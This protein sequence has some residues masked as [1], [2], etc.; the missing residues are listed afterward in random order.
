M[1]KISSVVDVNHIVAVA[2]ARCDDHGVTVKFSK[3]ASTAS[4]NGKEIIIPA[5]KNPVTQDA[6]D[7]L[8][9]YL[10]HE[11]GHHIRG[12]V[13]KILKAAKPGPELGALYNIV[14][15]E[16]M[17]RDM[18]SRWRGDHIALS[19][20]NEIIMEEVVD[21]WLPV[22]QA[23]PPKIP[24]DENDNNPI[25]AMVLQQMARLK[26]DTAH[27]VD[28]TH[29]ISNLPT[30]VRTLLD[31]LVN[32][33][34]HDKMAASVTEYD[35]WNTACELAKR[36]YPD[37][38]EEITTQQI[39]GNS[40]EEREG[41][42]SGTGEGEDSGEE[43][44]GEALGQNN[45][46]EGY[47]ISWKDAVLS[48]HDQP[49]EREGGI[50]GVGITW[51]DY[52]GGSVAMAPVKEINV[53]KLATK[54]EERSD[55]WGGVGAPSSFMCADQE[56]RA[57][58][59]QV[60]RY[61]QS[62]AKAQVSRHKRHGMLDKSALVKMAL[63]PIDKGDYNRKLFYRFD[64]R[65]VQ[66]TAVSILVD[67]SGSMIGTKMKLAA[68]AAGRLNFVLGKQIGL[69]TEVMAFTT[70]Y[71]VCDV[72]VVKDFHE[73][74]VSKEEIARRFSAF[75][76]YSS[77]NNDAD[78]VLLAYNRLLKRRESRRVLIVLSDGAP[79][80]SWLGGHADTNLRHVTKLIQDDKRN[81]IELWGVGIQ[82]DTVERY[83]N[84]NEVLWNAEDI[85]RT[86]FAIVKHGYEDYR[87]KQ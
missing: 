31:E 16:C 45:L 23:D 43:G 61:I 4:T 54:K 75:Y 35:S 10:I 65:N 63:P 42:E 1:T 66:D 17:E 24:W 19:N 68:D 49:G 11:C 69:P 50:A 80:D 79:T 9:G 30:E 62:R 73:R 47:N 84:R 55:D 6:M 29:I 41:D 8:Y 33:G 81:G 34:W 32:E 56:S 86:L 15:D 25:V 44:D 72:G 71:S 14:E 70:R 40:G 83:Y 74:M 5:I 78:A 60:R 18:A 21:N 77:G 67:W 48:E 57:L 26:W 59:N 46:K 7:K 82:S 12:D 52:T 58:G 28:L 27:E 51:E 37:M 20:A 87:R 3:Y 36:L 22:L 76:K 39:H 64:K 85:N 53:V 13:F 38:E 2:Q